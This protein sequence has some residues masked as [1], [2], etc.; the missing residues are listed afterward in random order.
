MALLS[1]NPENRRQLGERLAAFVCSPSFGASG[2]NALVGVIADLVADDPDMGPPLKDLVTRPSFQN[3]LPSAA[4]GGAGALAQ[5]DS[6]LS[7]LSRTYNPDIV[8]AMS[9]ILSG[10]LAIS[11]NTNSSQARSNDEARSSADSDSSFATDH[12]G[13][14]D[15]E[16]SDVENLRDLLASKQWH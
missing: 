4:Q 1:H 8:A 13:E 16:K 10:F 3:L 15:K 6:L 2:S 7:E 9:D 11:E 14:D 12:Q 5:R